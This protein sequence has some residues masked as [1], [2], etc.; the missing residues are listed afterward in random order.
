MDCGCGASAP[1][2]GWGRAP[3]HAAGA[4]GGVVAGRPPPLGPVWCLSYC[5]AH[6]VDQLVAINRRQGPE[7][8]RA[9]EAAK[10]GLAAG[11]GLGGGDPRP[12]ADP[13][14][15]VMV[16]SLPLF[17]P[18]PLPSSHSF[19]SGLGVSP[20]PTFSLL[21]LHGV[22]C[23]R[24]IG[25]GAGPTAAIPAGSPAELPS[26][27]DLGPDCRGCGDSCICVSPSAPQASRHPLEGPWRVGWSPCRAEG[28]F[29]AL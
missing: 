21:Q 22:V 15:A 28:P 18:S 4:L 17:P 26:W 16:S 19:L 2:A 9:R 24:P 12:R 29:E 3:P 8:L 7:P 23:G 11:W 13:S 5:G 14:P 27:L 1:P 10:L 20:P 25:K 6:R